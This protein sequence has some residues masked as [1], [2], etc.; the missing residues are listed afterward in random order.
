MASRVVP[1][2]SLAAF[3][4]QERG[5]LLV[6]NAHAVREGHLREAPEYGK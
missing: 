4:R 5:G 1:C 2:A 6:R 3:F